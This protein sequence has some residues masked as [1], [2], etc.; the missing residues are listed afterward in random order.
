[1]KILGLYFL[2][3]TFQVLMG[4]FVV[5]STRLLSA[6]VRCMVLAIGLT[7]GW[8]ITGYNLM[9]NEVYDGV[10]ASFVPSHTCTD[11]FSQPQNVGPWWKVYVLWNLPMLV[12]VMGGLQVRPADVP[13]QYIVA[14]VS[15]L[16]YAAMIFAGP[17][18][19]GAGMTEFLVMLITLFLATNLSAMVEFFTGVP[20]VPSIIPVLLLMTPA[21]YA[22]LEFLLVMQESAHVQGAK[23]STDVISY[24]LLKA[25]SFSLGMYIA[26][27]YWKPILLRKEIAPGAHKKAKAVYCTELDH[28]MQ[29]EL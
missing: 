7:I 26:L 14:Y 20:A 3:W 2:L 8:Q 5:G 29:K 28:V 19:N 24:L 22:V 23:T 12:G 17:E 15:F 9:Q 11:P 10:T 25:V 16:A 1:M 13:A 4:H 6:I 18:G 27:A 21:E